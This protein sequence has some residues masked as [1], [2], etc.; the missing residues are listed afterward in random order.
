M[1]VVMELAGAG[2]SSSVEALGTPLPTHLES[3]VVC[4]AA[5]LPSQEPSTAAHFLYPHG[6]NFS[7]GSLN[8]LSTHV[9]SITITLPSLH[10][11]VTPKFQV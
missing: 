6:K 2:D 9:F 11:E 7:E 4:A 8:Y 10:S 3:T 5:G 1:E